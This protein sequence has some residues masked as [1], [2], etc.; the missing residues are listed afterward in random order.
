MGDLE[1]DVSRILAES[2]ARKATEDQQA[3]AVGE[4]KP[5]AFAA[6][7]AACGEAAEL[8]AREE[9]APETRKEAVVGYREEQKFLSRRLVKIPMTKS[10]SGWI[11]QQGRRTVDRGGASYYNDPTW[12]AGTMFDTEGRLYRFRDDTAYPLESFDDAISRETL[13]FKTTVVTLGRV[14]ELQ[15]LWENHVTQ[16]TVRVIKGEVPAL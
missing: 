14:Q 6:F 4:A 3:R 16:A 12:L 13:G 8:L 11:L 15:G 7:V 5:T 9:I 10:I 2:D 1:K